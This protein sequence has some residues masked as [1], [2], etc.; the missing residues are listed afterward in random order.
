MTMRSVTRNGVIELDIL[1]FFSFVLFFSF[2][3]K[4][5]CLALSENENINN[6][7]VFLGSDDWSC[8][9]RVSIEITY[10]AEV[11]TVLS[12]L[13]QG[14]FSPEVPP[15]FFASFRDS[16]D[17]NKD[18][19]EFVLHDVL[20]ELPFSIVRTRHTFERGLL[21]LLRQD[22]H[23]RDI[24]KRRCT[25]CVSLMRCFWSVGVKLLPYKGTF[26]RKV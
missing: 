14:S 24:S 11:S 18:K 2:L 16:L 26:L 12:Y 5:V 1:L 9:D 4:L 15:N 3:P 7:N 17:V 8:Y 10:F 21:Q 23:F 6:K 22:L 25:W 19:M 20:E 13:F